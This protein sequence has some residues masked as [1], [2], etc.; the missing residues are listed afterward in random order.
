MKIDTAVLH[1]LSAISNVVQELDESGPNWKEVKELVEKIAKQQNY[2][3]D[4]VEFI[5]WWKD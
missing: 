1:M 5:D 4:L 2:Y 3:I